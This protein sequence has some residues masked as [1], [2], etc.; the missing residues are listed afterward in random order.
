MRRW[1]GW[2]VVL[3]LL[4]CGGAPEG[5]VA[6]PAA[7]E[8]ARAAAEPAE[9][10]RDEPRW[11]ASPMI[12]MEHHGE[13]A[14]AV[15]DALLDELRARIEGGAEI[16]AGRVR[17]TYTIYCS[18][19]ESAERIERGREGPWSVSEADLARLRAY[20][21]AA[22][23]RGREVIR[24][25]AE[26]ELGER[27]GIGAP[28]GHLSYPPNGGLGVR[29]RPRGRRRSPGPPRCR[30]AERDGAQPWAREVHES[31]RSGASA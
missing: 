2:L 19:G 9:P 10:T 16:R 24:G 15:L 22:A 14:R 12:V 6:H 20:A 5:A 28:E 13:A 23:G 11:V 26:G 21:E 30:V 18:F 29:G 17:V 25:P 3:G 1:G 31:S 27:V 4:G 7:D 8:S